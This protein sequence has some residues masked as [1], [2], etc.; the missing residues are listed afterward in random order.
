MTKIW[1]DILKLLVKADPQSFVSLM[2]AG[3]QFTGERDKELRTRT[4]DADL[5]YNVRWNNEDIVLHVEFQRKA[6][7]NMARRVWEY[8]VLTGCLAALPVY[9]VVLYLIEE[10]N[11][12]EPPYEQ[13]LPNGELVHYFQ[14]RNLK[15]WE[16]SSDKLR[17]L[18][19]EG[20]L[21]LLPL[22]KDG[23]Q[24]EIVEE[25]IAD[26]QST[27]RQDLY[28]LGYALAALVFK[29]S[30][31]KQWLKERFI[32][33]HD[34]LEES[35]AYQEML[36]TGMQKGLEKGMQKGIEQGMQKGIEQGMQKGIEQ[37]AEQAF[38][39]AISRCVHKRFPDLDEFCQQRLQ[40]ELHA[41]RLRD[42]F[43]VL[44]DA[45]HESEA[46]D[47]LNSLSPE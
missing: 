9:S 29:D 7:K 27:G 46:R 18:G 25:M 3:A 28:P 11:V 40:A 23:A 47:I 10:K 31:D 19:V 15:L 38:R 6:D 37:G 2:L 42:L 21:P 34:I 44:M 12:V 39:D 26:L 4:I 17:Q 36:E 45:T 41:D 22:T 43:D 13:R 5:L 8:N 30:A 1:D 33:M 32:R 16:M 35:W 24:R 14:F 20:M